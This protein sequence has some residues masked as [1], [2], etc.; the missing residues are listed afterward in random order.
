MKAAKAFLVACLVAFL[1][2]CVVVPVIDDSSPRPPAPPPRSE[3]PAVRIADLEASPVRFAPGRPIDFIVKIENRGARGFDFDIGVFHEARLVGWING[4]EIPRGMSS[5]RLKDDRFAGESGSYMV[6]VRH[7]D[8]VVDERRFSAWPTGDGRF[9]IDPGQAPRETRP[10]VEIENLEATPI[11]F[12]VRQPVDF[13]VKIENKG[14]GRSGFDVGVFH[15]GRLV[16]WQRNKSLRPGVNIF[17]LRDPGFT[18]DPGSYSVKVQYGSDIIGEKRFAT[19]R[20]SDGRYTLDPKN[21]PP[22]Q[23]SWVS[24]VDL[25]ALPVRFVPR[26]PIDFAV[27]IQNRGPASAGFDVGIFHEGRLVGWQTNK[28]L[29]PGVNV[30]RVRDDGF[31]GDPGSYI[32]KVRR[33]GRIIDEKRF[34]TRRVNALLFTLEPSDGPEKDRRQEDRRPRR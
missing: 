9:S 26:R 8:R 10:S 20:T 29:N 12:S 11:V 33:A 24:V 34:T 32:V 14:D 13:I 4:T 19:H 22:W 6:R 30:F 1:G 3:R 31:T 15:E 28:A 27:K 7:R 21:N 25:E 23:D 18:G 17:K 16:G 2:A 5:F